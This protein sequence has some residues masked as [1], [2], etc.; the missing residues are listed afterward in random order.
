MRTP[1]RFQ[2]RLLVRRSYK[3]I[4]GNRRALGIIFRPGSRLAVKITAGKES[5]GSP[6]ADDEGSAHSA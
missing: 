5:A 2:S 1:I 6:P 4:R 3:P